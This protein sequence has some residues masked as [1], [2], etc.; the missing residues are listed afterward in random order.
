VQEGVLH[1]KYK[2]FSVALYYD[3]PVFHEV[4]NR[5]LSFSSALPKN[6]K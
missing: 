3:L 4:G 1:M 6:V 5:I 2:E